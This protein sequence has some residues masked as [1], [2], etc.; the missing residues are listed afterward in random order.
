LAERVSEEAEGYSEVAERVSEEK[1]V[2]FGGNLGFW[3]VVC[4]A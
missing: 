2:V 3:G 1:R 4:V